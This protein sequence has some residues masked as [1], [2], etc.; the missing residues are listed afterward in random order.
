MVVEVTYVQIDDHNFRKIA[1]PGWVSQRRHYK[2]QVRRQLLPRY[3]AFL[4]LLEGVKWSDDAGSGKKVSDE[5]W[6]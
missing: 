5:L 3:R 1:F 6:R 4:V 2:R